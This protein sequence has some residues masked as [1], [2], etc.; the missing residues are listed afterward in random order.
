MGT[1]RCKRRS[2]EIQYLEKLVGGKRKDYLLGLQAGGFT[3]V[4]WWKPP[5]GILNLVSTAG[6]EVKREMALQ[7]T[8]PPPVFLLG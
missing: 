8:T 6:S 5:K 2:F 4:Q 1:Q 7:Q 3:Q